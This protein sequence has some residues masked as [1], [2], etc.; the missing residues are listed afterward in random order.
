VYDLASEPRQLAWRY[1]RRTLRSET[2]SAALAEARAE[3]D[4]IADF[5]AQ[6]ALQVLRQLDAAYDN[7]WNPAHPA[8]KPTFEKRSS[9][10]RLSLPGQAIRVRRISRHRGEVRIPKLGWQRSRWSRSPGGRMCSATFTEHAGRWYVSFGV[11]TDRELAGP[12]GKPGCGVDFGVACSAYV[13]DEDEPRLMPSS[14]TA[15]E[16]PRLVR[17]ERRKARQ[18]TCAK[19]HNQGRYSKRL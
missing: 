17:L 2:Q 5:P 18:L 8:R 19:K 6:D 1:G 11:A 4:W 10:L 3:I 7:W 14:L 15:G 12:N 13:S 16:Q 9:K